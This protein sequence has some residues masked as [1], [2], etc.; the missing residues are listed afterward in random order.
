VPADSTNLAAEFHVLS[1]LHR[2]GANATLT[3][4]NKK[5]VDIV[6]V[7]GAGRAITL[8]VK[9]AAGTTGFFVNNQVT[10]RPEHFVVFVSYLNNI[11][12][13]SI[14]PEIYIVPSG[15]VRSLA[16]MHPSGKAVVSLTA[17]RHRSARYRDAWK[18]IS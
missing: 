13:P 18:R 2:L 1:V 10:P 15:D 6:V 4:A 17:L 9:G 5:T 12:A 8:D 11:A 3:L 7:R 14:A 16:K